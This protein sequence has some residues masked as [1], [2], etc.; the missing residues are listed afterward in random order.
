MT[1]PD[2]LA[3]TVPVSDE[4]APILVTPCPPDTSY[5]Y[6]LPGR[7]LAQVAVMSIVLGIFGIIATFLPQ[8]GEAV[9]PLCASL[10]PLFALALAA[11]VPLAAAG[12]DDAPAAP[13][14]AGWAIV[15]GGAACDIY[16]TVTH[17][18][19]LAQE[20]NPVIRGLLDNGVSLE[21]VYLFGAILQVLFVGLTMVLWLGLLRHRH[22]L[23]ATLPPRGSV[24]AYFKAGTGGRELTYRQWLCPLAYSEL[25][26]AYHYAWW[27]G[28][29]FVGFSAYR[30]YLALEWYRVVP[31]HPL[32][33]RF[34][35]PSVALFVTGWW[36]GAW[37]RDARARLGP[38]GPPPA[39]APS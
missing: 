23:A 13:L 33:V 16:A 31:V 8:A 3:T 9:V 28:V 22:T 20:G 27:T 36:Y 30:F 17:S 39:N 24:L 35:A 14:L 11:A 25:P 6:A 26:W 32:W 21:R 19:D 1:D 10:V 37:L 5:G 34:I 12:K 29:A 4:E 38:E 7:R 15:L 2:Q 18:P